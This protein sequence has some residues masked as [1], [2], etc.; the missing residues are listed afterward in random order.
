MQIVTATVTGINDAADRQ[1][2]LLRHWEAKSDPVFVVNLLAG[3]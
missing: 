1:R 2:H 3:G